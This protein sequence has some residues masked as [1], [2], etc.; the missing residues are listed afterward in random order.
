MK[1][2]LYIAVFILVG[3][4]TYSQVEVSVEDQF[5][6]EESNPY[7]KDINGVLNKFE[8]EWEYT[9]AT[10]YLK[11]KF[12]KIENVNIEFPKGNWIF[13]E[14][15][16]FILYRELQG[17]NW[18]TI[19]NTYPA[20]YTVSDLANQNFNNY[21]SIHGNIIWLHNNNELHLE[22]YEPSPNC[23]R[24]EEQEL[25]LLYSTSSGNPQLNW[26]FGS[27]NGSSIV[28]PCNLET[29]NPIY[30]YRIPNQMILNKL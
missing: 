23:S 18:V 4:K 6:T 7:V 17:N 15:R 24:I 12:Y 25:I 13:D 14:L 26:Q 2:I 11:I 27:I 28:G 22:Y 9:D 30:Q 21:T 29:G 10:H 3:L 8:G 5:D 16:S 19:Y 1:N 20:S